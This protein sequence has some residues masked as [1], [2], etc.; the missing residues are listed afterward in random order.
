MTIKK[1]ISTLVLSFA[2]VLCAVL[3]FALLSKETKTASALST[4]WHIDQKYYDR[5][6]VGENDFSIVAMGDHQI[7]VTNDIWL[8][9]VEKS[10]EYIAANKDDMNLKMY[11]NLGD[12][13]DVVDYSYLSNGVVGT[14]PYNTAGNAAEYGA[15]RGGGGK[16][17]MT[18]DT[19]G[20]NIYFWQQKET[21][22]KFRN[23][24]A[25]A[26][27]PHS[28]LM[29]NHD[30]EDM[31]QSFRIKETFNEAYPLSMYNSVNIADSNSDGIVNE[32]DF[33]ETVE[34]Q[35]KYFGGSLYDDVENSYYYFMGNGKKYMVLNLGLHPDM[36]IVN[37]AS[38]VLEQNPNCFVIL[39]THA[40]FMGASSANTIYEKSEDRVWDKLV[41]CNDNVKMVLCGHDNTSDGGIN[42]R[43]DF[44]D[45]G[46]PVYQFMIDSQDTTY[47]GA[48]VFA[49]M[50][51]RESGD[52]DV[53]YYAPAFN[54]NTFVGDSGISEADVGKMFFNARSQFTFNYSETEIITVDTTGETVYGN[55]VDAEYLY[56]KF[57]LS[58]SSDNR[59]W[60]Q[61]LYA[62]NNVQSNKNTGLSVVDSSKPGYVVYHFAKPDANV[63]KDVNFAIDGSLNDFA[64]GT[65]AV[66]QWDYS[67][68]GT[69]W[70]TAVYDDTNIS[71]LS[72]ARHILRYI[73]GCK[74][75]YVRFVLKAD[76]NSYVSSLTFDIDYVQTEYEGS[77]LNIDYN[78]SSLNENNYDDMFL[79]DMDTAGWS[80]YMLGTGDRKDHLAGYGEFTIRLDSGSDKNFE[81]LSFSAVMSAEN[82][83]EVYYAR[84]TE[85]VID[86]ETREG[87]DGVADTPVT[88]RA[89]TAELKGS[90]KF[91]MKLY[92]S[93]DNGATFTLVHTENA[94][95]AANSNY[96]V[97][98]IDVS[99]YVYGVN[100]V[101]LKIAFFSIR[102]SVGGF[103]SFNISGTY[104]AAPAPTY[105]ANGGVAW[106]SEETVVSKDGY[107][108]E[109]WHL[110]SVDGEKV[111]PAEYA[112]QNVNLVAK[113]NKLIKITYVLG[114][115]VNSSENESV[116]VEGST[117]TLAAAT[118]EGYKFLGWYD[119]NGNKVSSFTATA[120]T[121]LYAAWYQL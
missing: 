37:W 5:L 30:Y 106:G 85:K 13:F 26:G 18:S 101:Q 7:A 111:N 118:R 92:V 96:T 93:T 98:P 24:L 45:F 1:K 31:A 36:D 66:Y 104:D 20:H 117:V 40:Y 21:N 59:R 67:F 19:Y 58:N 68:D 91:L 107:E 87:I 61:Y 83:N 33:D 82:L 3:G 41:K 71:V 65:K 23:M 100:S 44:N 49:Q 2:I 62:F 114:E 109:G 52:I 95:S 34:G 88:L 86:A 14:G 94:P 70:Q 60:A 51:F 72:R 77:T 28:W 4:Q 32:D 50:I 112:D 90:D 99:S 6:T 17:G 9:Y 15:N 57:F 110:G 73:N 75:L 8:R 80:G 22:I 89:W 10:Y 120:H 84:T 102:A 27:V 108:F 38:E 64:D 16:G 12:V 63:F 56:D 48:G 29:G 69:T 11:I 79:N 53:C 103:K 39:N 74:D 97:S 105:N 55:S 42:K 116:V 121:V 81:T 46:N 76:S 25:D 78:M 35:G 43:V 54:D 113:W 47:G 119:I 115:G